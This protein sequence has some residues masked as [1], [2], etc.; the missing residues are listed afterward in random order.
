AISTSAAIN[1]GAFTST[2]L[3]PWLLREFG[4]GWAFGVPG[5]L[6]GLA[7]WV[8]WLGRNKFVHIPPTGNKVFREIVSPDSLRALANLLPL[9]FIFLV[10]FWTLFDQTQS[11]WIVQAREMDR[12]VLGWNLDVAA[13]QAANPILVLILV[14]LFATVI[15]PALGKFVEVTPLRKMGA[16][17]FFGAASFAICALAQ[18]WIDQGHTPSVWW[19]LLAYAVLTAGEVVLSIT[20]LEFS[21]SQAPKTIK[22]VIIGVYW[23]SV[24][25]ANFIIAFVNSQIASLEEAGYSFLTGENYFWTFSAASLIAGCLF[26]VWSQFYSGR[27]YIQGED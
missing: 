27:T 23:L 10:V 9:Y 21:Y 22:S 17:F 26:A 11:T 5:V 12:D 16:G 25:A 20:A 24:S 8:F 18:N 6:M 2:L 7:T 3:T 19:Q 4:P 13:L 1:V 15:Y 14:P